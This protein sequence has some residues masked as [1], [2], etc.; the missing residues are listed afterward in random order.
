MLTI[1]DVSN[2]QG[3][4]N[5]KRVKA[6]GITLAYVKATEA[7]TY[8]DPRFASNRKACAALGIR[9]GAYAFVQ[10]SK[11]TPESQAAHFCSIVGRLERRDLRP[12]QDL[13]VGTRV[14]T[15]TFARAFS[16]AVTKRLGC[17]PLLYSYAPFLAALRL[18]RPIGGGLW[19]A[20][21]G[22]NDGL[23][24]G[25][26]VPPPWKHWVAHQYTSRSHADGIA[27]SVDFSHAPKLR[28]LLA[29]PI[30]GLR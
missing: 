19:L 15:E 5:W 18:E 23:D 27:G 9:F 24:H 1:I 12:A 3:D 8:T 4:V 10:P 13:E 11:G 17:T 7:T 16:R 20:A 30:T 25:A 6:D 22:R 28:P 26:A 29:H 14:G 21:Y 2:W